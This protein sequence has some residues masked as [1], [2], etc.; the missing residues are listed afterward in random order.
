M[1]STEERSHTQNYR[2]RV[3]RRTCGS[4]IQLFPIFD[5]SLKGRKNYGRAGKCR[6]VVY[7][8]VIWSSAAI[9]DRAIE[10]LVTELHE[11]LHALMRKLLVR[12]FINPK[13]GEEETV[14][15][16]SIHILDEL[17]EIYRQNGYLRTWCEIEIDNPQ[18][19]GQ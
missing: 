16:L 13:I 6:S 3:M 11:T 7:L 10:M 8:N 4:S 15:R 18:R 2:C 9:Y 14:K 1:T 19:S 12:S 5:Y 17:A